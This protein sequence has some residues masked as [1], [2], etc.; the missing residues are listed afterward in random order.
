MLQ[1]IKNA[2]EPWRDNQNLVEEI[3]NLSS[4]CPA[5]K[6]YK[7]V[8]PRPVV[9]LPMATEFQETV[10]M[11]LKF[12][13]SKILIHLV[14]YCTRLSASSFI[15]NKNSDT[16]LTFIFKIWVSIYGAPEK[17]LTDNGGEFVNT[18]FI[19]MAESLGITAKTTAAETPWSNGLIERHNL[20]LAD[21]VN[22]VLD[23]TQ[24]HPDLRVSC[25]I[26][27][28][29]SLHSVHGFSPYQLA[30]GKNPK[31]PFVL[32]EKVPALTR[33]PTSKIVSNNLDA[34]HKARESFISSENSEKIRRTLSR[35]IRSSG[36]VKYVTGDSVYYK[37][38]DSKE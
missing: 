14:D 13:D 3:K 28:K 12:Y 15:P 22:K 36:D 25:C 9:G 35:N 38:I 37:C 8:P 16:I 17:F 7:K 2:G 11:D 30:I 6:K 33:Q 20:V 27:A 32:N 1:L 26:N 19:E 29:N 5:C 23:D 4:N 10:A 21:M 18:K 34:I 31:L 24:C